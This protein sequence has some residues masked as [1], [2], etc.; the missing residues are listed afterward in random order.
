MLNFCFL[1]CCLRVRLGGRA[2]KYR[3]RNFLPTAYGNGGEGGW[4]RMRKTQDGQLPA[5]PGH[6][7]AIFGGVGRK[8]STRKTS[9]AKKRIKKVGKNNGY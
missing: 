8:G 2:Q 5:R 6:V 9:H 1:H 7:I 3:E 4:R